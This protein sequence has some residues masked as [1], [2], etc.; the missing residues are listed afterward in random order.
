MNIRS[1]TCPQLPCNSMCGIL[2]N[3][4]PYVNAIPIIFIGFNLKSSF[5]A[6]FARSFTGT[7]RV[8]VA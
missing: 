5:Q 8:P 2:S 7:Y 6:E 4:S 3:R 1:I